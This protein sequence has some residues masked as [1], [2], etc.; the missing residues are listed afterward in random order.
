MLVAHF[1]HAIIY[2]SQF[3]NP[4]SEGEIIF[5]ALSFILS[6]KLFVI[7]EN[8]VNV[9]PRFYWS[10]VLVLM[11][12][13]TL[14]LLIVINHLSKDLILVQSFSVDDEEDSI[15]TQNGQSAPLRRL[16]L[17]YLT[18]VIIFVKRLSI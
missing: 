18:N 12:T 2:C 4:I 13:N 16:L 8:G 15:E 1:I 11:I 14:M 17:L 10:L 6:S 9:G 7:I 5:I 3:L